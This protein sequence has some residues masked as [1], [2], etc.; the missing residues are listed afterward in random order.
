ML[1]SDCPLFLSLSCT[2]LQV[3]P[4]IASLMELQQMVNS[5]PREATLN[6]PPQEIVDLAKEY[7]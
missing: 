3:Q 2:D 1:D 7:V 6:L 4:L 5:Q